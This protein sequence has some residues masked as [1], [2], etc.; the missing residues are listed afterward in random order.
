M[1]RIDASRESHGGCRSQARRMSLSALAAGPEAG[2]GAAR[3][4]PL[5]FRDWLERRLV[6]RSAGF[7][8]VWRTRD[9][10]AVRRSR[11]VVARRW[12][13]SSIPSCCR[14]C[15]TQLDAIPVGYDLIV[16][17]ASRQPITVDTSD[18]ARRPPHGRAR[19][20]EP[21]PRHLADRPGRQRRAARPVRDRA[22]GAHQ[23]Q[24][25]ARPSMR[26]S[27]A[28]ASSGAPTCST[29]CSAR[30]ATSRPILERLRRDP[31]PGCGRP[32][33]ATCSARSSGA[34]TRR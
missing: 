30:R 29:A 28:A 16:T 4:P 11:A 22:E 1:R 33:R 7:P 9:R 3:T 24:R 26:S 34:A 31:E 25:M 10:S 5:D 12:C 14:S 8:D 17:N 27:P 19:G 18:A 6:A 15:S 21:R 20:R 13:T 23:A 32:R 2:S